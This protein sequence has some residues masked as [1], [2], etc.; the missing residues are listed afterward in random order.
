MKKCH[1][2][3]A[4]S[5]ASIVL[6]S[7]ELTLLKLLMLSF[8]SSTLAF[9]RSR[10]ASVWLRSRFSCLSLTSWSLITLSFCC[11]VTEVARL[12]CSEC[13]IWKRHKCSYMSKNCE[14]PCHSTYNDNHPSLSPS[15]MSLII[16][17][18]E[19]IICLTHL[20]Q[21]SLNESTLF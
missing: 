2:L 21:P 14:F 12:T 16:C 19:L 11:S 15:V 20:S 13:S 3:T 7:P 5:L 6:S 1:K 17:I 18:K 8:S 9:S 4:A 10:S